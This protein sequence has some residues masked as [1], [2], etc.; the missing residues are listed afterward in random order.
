LNQN[1]TF[2]TIRCFSKSN[3]SWFLA[4][5]LWLYN[6]KNNFVASNLLLLNISS[7]IM[8]CV[9]DETSHVRPKLKTIYPISLMSQPTPHKHQHYTTE[10]VTT[11]KMVE[12]LSLTYASFY[13]NFMQMKFIWGQFNN[14]KPPFI[15]LQ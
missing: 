9:K 15:L 14:F 7:N 3:L 12:S 1:P 4:L 11:V 13:V 8:N 5:T 10:H 6:V 2:N